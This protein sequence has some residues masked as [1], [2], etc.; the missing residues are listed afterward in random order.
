MHSKVHK[1]CWTHLAKYKNLT[2]NILY[3]MK[4]KKNK[5]SK[6]EEYY[7]EFLTVR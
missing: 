3:I 7:I 1:F 2:E 4:L 6:Q 5:L